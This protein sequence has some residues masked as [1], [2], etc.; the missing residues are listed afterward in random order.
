MNSLDSYLWTAARLRW[1]WGTCDCSM[2]A[3]DWTR[4]VVGRDPAVGIRGRYRDREGARI[5]VE[6]RGG[7]LRLVGEQYEQCGLGPT[8][9]PR[10]GD[11]GVVRVPNIYDEDLE[12]SRAGPVMA[13]YR[14]GMWV[15]KTAFG[16]AG[17]EYEALGAW[18]VGWTS[19]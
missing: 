10:D 8:T 15:V 13:I 5:L 4:Q 18:G 16:I 7:L 2:L 6:G 14:G 12:T 1:K 3:A 11:V 19:S 9:S 17:E